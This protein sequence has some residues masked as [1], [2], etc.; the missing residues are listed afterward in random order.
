MADL[1]F[2]PELSAASRNRLLDFSLIADLSG[3]DLLVSDAETGQF[4]ACNPSAAEH[5][6]YSI[7]ELLQL[8]PEAL[9]AD[10]AHDAAWVA[11][12]RQELLA[13]GSA[14][15]ET[16]HRTKTDA[17]L[18]VELS[19]RV[20]PL[21]GRPVILTLVRDC[22]AAQ[23]REGELLEQLHLLND[24]EALSG[25]GV[26]DLRFA[27]GRMRW[28]ERMRRLCRSSAATPDTT[29]WAYGAL[30][31]PDD[32]L[33]WRQE[34]QR[35][36]NRGDPFRHRHRLAFLDGTDLLVQ[37]EASFSYDHSGQPVRAIGTLKDV[38]EERLFLQEQALE[39]SS[40][41]LTGLPNKLASLDGLNR[42]LNGRSYNNSLALFSLDVDG[43]QEI[44]DNFGS[45]VGD[46]VLQVMAQR[47]RQ[48]VGEQA[49]LARLSSDQF[50]IV[51]EDQINPL[52]MR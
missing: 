32:R 28:S 20:L 12:R 13:S 52:V 25:I 8:S 24:G 30:V 6:G 4:L 47:L 11:A 46:R 29:F 42:R 44:N 40:D 38:S 3:L 21:D 33:R 19:H 7:E 15:F 43:F 23:Q 1:G 2:S 18:E 37:A 10:P 27:D 35:A 16:R 45:D 48:L 5:L 36:V 49:W 39:R 22:G 51:L 50:L 26:W 17:I 31:H 9:Q 41:P 14:V 34:F